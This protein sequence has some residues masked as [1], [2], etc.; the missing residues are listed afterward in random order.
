VPAAVRN[1]A[2]C[3]LAYGPG[4]PPGSGRERIL[5][6]RYCAYFVPA[7]PL[8]AVERVRVAADEVERTVE[9]VRGLL[10][11]RG[12]DRAAWFVGPSSEPANLAEQ[13]AALGMTPCDEP[14]LEPRYRAMVLMWPPSGG[15]VSGIDAHPVA[16]E[17]ELVAATRVVIDSFGLDPA[18]QESRIRTARAAWRQSQELPDYPYRTYVAVVDGEVVGSAIAAVADG[19]FALMG[20]AVRPAARGRG[21]YRALLQARWDDAV[22]A[23]TPALA[24]AAGRMSAPILERSGFVTVAELTVLCDR[25]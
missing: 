6:V 1:L 14:P 20:G 9:E 7:P 4:P 23:G 5:D 2:E 8:S 16:S 21:V 25:I 22:A 11:E 12:H 19:A 3:P 10:R 13:L 15:D 18:H 24:V 17:S